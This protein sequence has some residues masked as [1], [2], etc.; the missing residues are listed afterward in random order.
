MIVKNWERQSWDHDGWMVIEEQEC[1]VQL[2]RHHVPGTLFSVPEGGSLDINFATSVCPDVYYRLVDV[3]GQ[4]FKRSL[5]N[6]YDLTRRVEVEEGQT[7]VSFVGIDGSE[8]QVE[9]DGKKESQRLLGHGMPR[10]WDGTSRGDL[11]L[12]FV[13]KTK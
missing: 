13:R 1:K 11:I 4:E 8:I 7:K 6:L 5:G 12:E 10:N 2:Q 9:I 3:E